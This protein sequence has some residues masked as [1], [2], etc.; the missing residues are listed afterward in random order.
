MLQA[1]TINILCCAGLASLASHLVKRKGTT[2][3]KTR[4]PTLKLEDI[5]YFDQTVKTLI[6]L[7]SN[8]VKRAFV[9]RLL[10]CQL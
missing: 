8:G 6:I 9:N 5:A 10:H 3:Y 2:N 7:I 1:S 4:F